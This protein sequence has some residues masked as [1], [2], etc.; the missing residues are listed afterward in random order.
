MKKFA[1]VLILIAA[2][3]SLFAET[4][5]APTIAASTTLTFGVDLGDDSGDALSTGFKNETSLKISVYIYDKATSVSEAADYPYAEVTVKDI[6]VGYKEAQ[7]TQPI[8]ITMGSISGVVYV[9]EALKFTLAGKPGASSNNAKSFEPWSKTRPDQGDY[10]NGDTT[11]SLVAAN[12]EQTPVTNAISTLTFSDLQGTTVT[13]D[14]GAVVLDLDLV[15]NVLYTE[16]V[17]NAYGAGLRVTVPIGDISIYAG[18]YYGTTMTATEDNFEATAGVKLGLGDTGSVELAADLE[19]SP[20]AVAP[21]TMPMDL[22][23]KA[24]LVFGEAAKLDVVGYLASDDGDAGDE[25]ELEAKVKL[26]LTAVENLTFTAETQLMD[27]LRPNN[28][29]VL[30]LK[31]GVAYDLGG[32]KPFANFALNAA[33]FNKMMI[34][35]GVDFS[36]L[37]NKAVVTLKYKIDN[38]NADATTTAWTGVAGGVAVDSGDITLAIKGSF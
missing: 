13:F 15:S 3:V 27:V 25:L 31:I 33:G 24:A 20:A 34:E 14:A 17:D 4:L 10:A 5:V 26:A 18:A 37:I 12:V 38:L 9:S 19:L 30:G 7:A 1:L 23:L 35:G 8:N 6:Q 29:F 32:I 22:M 16:N 21:A 28:D 2:T 36:N 11:A